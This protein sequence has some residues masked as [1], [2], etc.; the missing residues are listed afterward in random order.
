M[1]PP[2]SWLMTVVPVLQPLTPQAPS[3]SSLKFTS[4]WMAMTPR[5]EE[6]LR[7][8]L[9]VPMINASTEDAAVET[10]ELDEDEPDVECNFQTRR[11]K[12][13][14]RE[15]RRGRTDSGADEDLKSQLPEEENPMDMD[16]DKYWHQRHILFSRY[17][18]GIKLDNEGWFSVTSEPIAKH[19]AFRCGSHTVIDGF[20]GV[21]GNAIQFAKSGKNVIAIDIDQKRIEYAKH[22]AAIYEVDDKI[23]FV[24]GDFFLLAPKLKAD[25]VFLSPP[26][27]GPGYSK[28]R[29]YDIRTMLKPRDGFF[30]FQAA[31]QIASEVV[32]FLPK[33]VDLNQ[34]AEMALSSDPPWSLEV[35]KNFLNGKFKAITAYFTRPRPETRTNPQ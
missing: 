29:T 35:E 21:G 3:S 33:N 30:L 26:W 28:V 19:H 31:K 7:R 23:D 11:G 27:G 20:A 32:M 1:P 22:N 10:L 6:S 16:I 8:P 25:A 2:L 17:D 14:T 4:G 24:R 34:L 13:R 12:K 9:G 15:K 5:R 18:D